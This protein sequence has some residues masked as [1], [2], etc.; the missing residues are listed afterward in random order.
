MDNRIHCGLLP[1][2]VCCWYCALQSRN[3]TCLSNGCRPCAH[4]STDPLSFLQCDT[5]K[6][7]MD[8]KFWMQICHRWQEMI[9]VARRDRKVILK[10]RGRSV[11]VASAFMRQL[12]PHS[13]LQLGHKILR[14]WRR[15]WRHSFCHHIATVSLRLFG[16]H[17][18][19]LGRKSGANSGGLRKNVKVTVINFVPLLIEPLCRHRRWFCDESTEPHMCQPPF[20]RCSPFGSSWAGGGNRLFPGKSK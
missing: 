13:K 16:A 9:L 1:N 15:R 11:S 4:I 5:W 18:G 19:S 20:G 8:S 14:N 6:D 10:R 12:Q 17:L 7:F 2:T 3:T